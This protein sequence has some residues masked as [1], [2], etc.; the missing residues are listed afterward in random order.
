[1]SGLH[2]CLFWLSH[3]NCIHIISFHACYLPYSSQLPYL[4]HVAEYLNVFKVQSCYGIDILS[5]IPTPQN[6]ETNIT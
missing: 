4:E 6:L 5:D 3:R 1:M 2:N